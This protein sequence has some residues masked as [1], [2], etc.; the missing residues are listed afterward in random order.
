MKEKIQIMIPTWNI[1]A[2]TGYRPCTTFWQDFSIADVF[3]KEA[4]MDTFQRAFEEWKNNYVFITELVM[5]LNHKIA[6]WY[7]KNVELAKLY[8]RYYHAVACYAEKNLKGDKLE[9][10]YRITD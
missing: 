3:G 5:V 8:N 9:Y 2:M 6:Q 1:E 7:E 10:Y 4:V